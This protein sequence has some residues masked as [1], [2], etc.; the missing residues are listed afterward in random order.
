MRPYLWP[1]R[2]VKLGSTDHLLLQ[3]SL[4]FRGLATKG[5]FGNG[6]RED[7][8]KSKIYTILDL[9]TAARILV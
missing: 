8:M 2:V 3:T 6:L 5:R 1:F 9:T 7:S 4:D